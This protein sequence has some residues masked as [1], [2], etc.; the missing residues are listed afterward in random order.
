MS[1][2]GDR[3]TNQRDHDETYRRGPKLRELGLM[4]IA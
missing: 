1:N 2:N 3:A 4:R